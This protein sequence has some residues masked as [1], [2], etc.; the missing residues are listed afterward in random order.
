MDGSAEP[1]LIVLQYGLN[2][3]RNV[4]EEYSYY[5]RGIVRQLDVIKKA[6]PG[7]PVLIIG[8]TNM[9]ELE[10]DSIKPFDNIGKIVAAQQSAAEESSAAFWNA[11]EKMGGSGSVPVWVEKRLMQTYFTHLTYAGADTLASMI[12]RDLFLKDS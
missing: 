1:D 5:Q 11:Y 9:A 4:R 6:L 3:V 7:V 8:V 2:I 12:A 10:G